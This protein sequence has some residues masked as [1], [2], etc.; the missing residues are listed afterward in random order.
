MSELEMEYLRQENSML[1]RRLMHLTKNPDYIKPP[2]HW[3]YNPPETVLQPQV[4][5]NTTVFKTVTR[6]EI[7]NLDEAKHIIIEVRDKDGEWLVYRYMVS[8]LE[9]M[10]GWEYAE[11]LHKRLLRSL[12][13]AKLNKE[14]KKDD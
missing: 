1:K 10:D 5:T 2:M 14:Y 6:G 12:A 3:A 13:H 11:E 4:E 9:L 8:D 7:K